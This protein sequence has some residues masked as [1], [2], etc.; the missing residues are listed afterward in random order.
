METPIA[1]AISQKEKG[2]IIGNRQ[3]YKSN[4]SAK[5]AVAGNGLS[6]TN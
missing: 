4:K 1:S 3:L 5:Y 2:M 6:F